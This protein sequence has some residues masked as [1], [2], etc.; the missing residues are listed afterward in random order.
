MIGVWT[1]GRYSGHFVRE[2]E[3]KKNSFWC[4]VLHIRGKR[5]KK[6]GEKVKHTQN[7]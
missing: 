1:F 2:E 7:P 3:E 6:K 4:L 5:K